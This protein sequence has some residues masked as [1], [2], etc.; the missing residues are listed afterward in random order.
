[1]LIGLD[2]SRAGK[3]VKTGTEWYSYQLILNLA[4]IDFKNNYTLYTRS[5]SLDLPPNLPKNFQIKILKWQCRFFWTH[6]RLS[7]EMLTNSPDILFVPA[8]SVPLIHRG[9]TIVTI[10]DLGFLHFPEVYHFLVKYYHRFS[11]WWSVKKAKKIITISNFTKSDI[12]K[13][14]KINSDKIEVIPLGINLSDF[15]R[16]VTSEDI[17]RFNLIKPYFLYIGRLE[18]KK[19][20]EFLIDT[21]QEFVLKN[22]NFDLVLIGADGYGS[23]RI[24]K[25]IANTKNIKILGYITESEKIVLLKKCHAFVFPSIFEGFGLPVLEA[26]AAGSLILCADTS[27]L[28]EVGGEAVWYFNNNNVSSLLKLMLKTTTAVNEIIKTKNLAIERAKLFTWSMTA[29]KTLFLLNKSK[30]Q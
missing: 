30:N 25:K 5:D 8:H 1:M 7:W 2:A 16:K 29:E 4:K 18:K 23:D 24:R 3:K 10:H 6:F 20:I 13:N 19:N 17:N 27:S 15:I 9:R 21:W 14:Y 12:L 26:M 28:P 11:A 22:N